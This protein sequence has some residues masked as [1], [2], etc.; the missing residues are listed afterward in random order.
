MGGLL[1]HSNRHAYSTD[2]SDARWQVL[3]PLLSFEKPGGRHCSYPMREV[4]NA[5]QYVLRRGCA[6]HLMPHW[7]WAYEYFRCWKKDGTWRRVYDPLHAE[8]RTRMN[9]NVRPSAS[10]IDSQSVK[11]MGKGGFTA[12]MARRRLVVAIDI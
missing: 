12:M 8:V 7:R 5:I 11:T 2:L 1:R 10:I 3:E 4:I 9:R 6:C